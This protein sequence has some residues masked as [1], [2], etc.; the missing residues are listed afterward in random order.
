MCE[1]I[2][3]T[4]TI[5]GRIYRTYKLHLYISVWPSEICSAEQRNTKKGQGAS[6]LLCNFKALT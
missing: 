3:P 4:H 2:V 1:C 6:P 5:T